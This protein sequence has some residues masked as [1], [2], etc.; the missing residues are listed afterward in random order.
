MSKGKFQKKGSKI[1]VLMLAMMLVFGM[2]VGGTLAYLMAESGTVTNTFTVGDINIKLEEHK[3]DGT[4][5]NV[6]ETTYK[7]L[8]DT[9]QG[10][11]PFVT[12]LANS[13]NCYV[14]VEVV[15]KNN[16][17]GNTKA[18]KYI[19]YSVDTS[20]WT[21]IGNTNIYYTTTSYATQTTDKTYS[22]LTGNKVSY[23]ADLTKADLEKVTDNNK[24]T[25]TFKAYAVQKEAGTDAATAWN[26]TFGKNT[27]NAG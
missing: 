12:V 6:G 4:V 16:D 8:P 7:I 20:V 25:L 3:L 24:P 17:T 9:E 5:T 15:E 21:Q 14:Y 2:A 23:D 11:D 27:S 13:E 18:P 10:K 1:L 22:V 19:T 26:N